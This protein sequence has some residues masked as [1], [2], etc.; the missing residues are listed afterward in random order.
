MTA[1]SRAQRSLEL[2]SWVVLAW[3][4]VAASWARVRWMLP[5]VVCFG[6]LF[7]L[8]V[9]LGR[10]ARPQ[11][12]P[13]VV[14]VVGG[15]ALLALMVMT[16]GHASRFAP[17]VPVLGVVAASWLGV[18]GAAATVAVV[19]V[20]SMF[21]GRD[22]SYATDFQ[23]YVALQV[24][25]ACGAVAAVPVMTDLRRAL[26]QAGQVA[27]AAEEALLRAVRDDEARDRFLT[28][29]S[30]ELRTPLDAVQG[31][32]EMLA[33]DERDPDRARDL[34]RVLQATRHL[35][36]LVDD[37]IDMSRAD[38]ELALDE[39][40]VDLDALLREVVATTQ[41]LVTAENRYEVVPWGALPPVWSDAR[42]VRQIL[43]NLVTNAAKYT[44]RGAV[45]LSA[46]ASGGLVSIEVTD[47]GVGIPAHRQR[48]LFV[49]FMQLHEGTERRPGVGLGLALSQRLA[50][51]L[52]GRIVARSEVGRGSTF[53]LELPARRG[54]P[55]AQASA[56]R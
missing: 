1:T 21:V 31:Y 26:E 17:Y 9:A 6:S 38:G 46:R 43:L 54:T 39:E 14:V 41:P 48:D 37:M 55:S 36:S 11:L 20:V 29:V 8:G 49:P 15:A 34:A 47:T 19:G 52:G 24:A 10:S 50:Q 45:T 30:H 7:W 42:R 56:G 51:R 35:G 32:T 28:S 16:G 22:P 40:E 27:A 12:G 5:G 23:V 33:E 25:V 44:T 3:V 53:T 4:V 18:R 2:L 13:L